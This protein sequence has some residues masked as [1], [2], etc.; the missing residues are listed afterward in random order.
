MTYIRVSN[1]CDYLC[2]RHVLRQIVNRAR[3]RGVLSYARACRVKTS[4]NGTDVIVFVS[5]V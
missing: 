5:L 4:V 1:K 3:A 2:V